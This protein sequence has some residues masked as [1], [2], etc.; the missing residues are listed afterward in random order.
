[1]NGNVGKIRG[2]RSEDGRK[3]VGRERKKYTA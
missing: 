2:E 1:V 3:K